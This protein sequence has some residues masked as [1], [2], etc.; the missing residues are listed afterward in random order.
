MEAIN[1]RDGSHVSDQIDLYLTGA[2]DAEREERF[3]EHLL[4]C[5]SCRREADESSEVAVAVAGLPPGF[6]AELEDGDRPAPAGGDRTPRATSA[7]PAGRQ[8]GRRPESRR[9][10]RARPVFTYLATL[11]VGALLGGGWMLY[12]H[13][14]P[15]RVA[16]ANDTATGAQGQLAVTVTP[17][18]GGVEVRAVV[19][20]LRPATPYDLL[21]VT[22]DGRTL[23]VAHGVAAGGP[24][25]VVGTVRVRA[26]QCRFFAVV[27]GAGDVLLVAPAG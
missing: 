17:R 27:Q 1:G 4:R 24:Q 16:A 11:L 23:T 10:S 22:T 19:V 14:E 12:Q 26:A 2:L 6:V 8:D 3:E 25:T 21:A 20:G 7:R 18:S 13:R 5:A 9:R 15:D